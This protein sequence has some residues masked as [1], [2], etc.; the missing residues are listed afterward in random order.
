MKNS[1]FNLMIHGDTPTSGK[2]YD[3]IA[4]NMI[5][6]MIGITKQNKMHYLPFANVIPYEDFLFFIEPKEFEQN[7]YELLENIIHNTEDAVYQSMMSNLTLYK[8]HI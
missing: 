4:F 7:G 5:N 3:S 8:K 6:I 2:F 1:K